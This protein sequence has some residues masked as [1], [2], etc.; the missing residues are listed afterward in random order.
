MFLV[1]VITNVSIISNSVTKQLRIRSDSFVFL[2]DTTDLNIFFYKFPISKTLAK[3]KVFSILFLIIGIATVQSEASE[4]CRCNHRLGVGG[5][6][7][8]GKLTQRCSEGYN[9]F[10]HNNHLYCEVGYSRSLLEACCNSYG[11]GGLKCLES[12]L[13]E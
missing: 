12:T 7:H 9:C 8:T 6:T 13:T 3:M 5:Q 10:T 1:K 2:D 11:A 4:I